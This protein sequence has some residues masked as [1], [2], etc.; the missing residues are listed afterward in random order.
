[1]TL[2]CG[3]RGE[4]NLKDLVAEFRKGA[5]M[6]RRDPLY[7]EGL[8]ENDLYCG[9]CTDGGLKCAC[10]RSTFEKSTGTEL[11]YLLLVTSRRMMHSFYQV[12]AELTGLQKASFL[13]QKKVGGVSQIT[14]Q[15]VLLQDKLHVNVYYSFQYSK[16]S[17]TSQRNFDLL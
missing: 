7:K 3:S 1:M 4:K 14:F 12:S 16:E 9:D 10:Y 5:E 11:P 6:S 8:K 2:S 13:H 17:K 15:A